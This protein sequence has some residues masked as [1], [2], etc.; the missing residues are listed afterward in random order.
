ME[1]PYEFLSHYYGTNKQAVM[2]CVDRVYDILSRDVEPQLIATSIVSVVR[3]RATDKSMFSFLRD[4]LI[5]RK[6]NLQGVECGAN[7][8]TFD[9]PFFFKYEEHEIGVIESEI[10][11][12]TNMGPLFIGIYKGVMD[13][14]DPFQEE[15]R[16]TIDISDG[17]TNMPPFY[18]GEVVSREDIF[19]EYRDRIDQVPGLSNV[20]DDKV[21]D[22][23]ASEIILFGRYVKRECQ[24]SF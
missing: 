5:Y 20:I 23:L 14:E 16:I 15:P 24:R 7:F 6:G 8:V 10:K 12:D 1:D 17:N 2:D 4:F 11:F 19:M 9:S 21:V 3:D 18:N 13:V 22:V